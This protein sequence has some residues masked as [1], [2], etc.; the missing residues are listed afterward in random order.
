MLTTAILAMAILAMTIVH[1][2]RYLPHAQVLRA[3][4]HESVRRRLGVGGVKPL[5]RLQPHATEAATA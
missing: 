3:E 5:A 1:R 2:L 4:Q